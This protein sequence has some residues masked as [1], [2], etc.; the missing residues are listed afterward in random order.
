MGAKRKDSM[1]YM[2]WLLL[3]FCVFLTPSLALA[4]KLGD[5]TLLE[6]ETG[7]FELLVQVTDINV[8]GKSQSGSWKLDLGPKTGQ[9]LKAI[10]MALT[11]EKCGVEK[12]QVNTPGSSHE[13]LGSVLKGKLLIKGK[14]ALERVSVWIAPEESEC[15]ICEPGSKWRNVALPKVLENVGPG[16]ESDFTIMYGY[17]GQSETDRLKEKLPDPAKITN[18]VIT[19]SVSNK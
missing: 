16:E 3:L 2:K 4:L 18:F 8:K 17:L 12:Y 5:A 7:T 13:R 9:K 14:M 6:M 19:I 10:T 11:V 15:S 1:R